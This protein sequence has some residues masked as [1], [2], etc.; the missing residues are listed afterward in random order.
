MSSATD[1]S[2]AAAADDRLARRNAL[3]LAI[4]QALAGGNNTVIVATSGIAGAMLAPDRGLATLPISVMVLGLWIGTLPVGALAK[5]HGRRFAFQVGSGFGT[6]AG[7][8]SSLAV[9][10]RSFWLLL[11]GAFRGGLY[12]A[13]H[14]AYRF[15]A[16]DTASERFKP[17]ALTSINTHPGR[18]CG[19]G[20]V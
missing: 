7:L 5:A 4:A 16:A 19:T 1:A 8:I 10:Q 13:A 6:L 2:I 17:K 12:A 3:V 9:F 15:A 20:N 14:Q 18:G 11:V